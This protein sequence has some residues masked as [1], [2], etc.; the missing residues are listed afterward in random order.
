MQRKGKE[1]E[2]GK[3]YYF[4][5]PSDR[6]DDD[7]DTGQTVWRGFKEKTTVHGIPHTNS[8]AGEWRVTAWVPQTTLSSE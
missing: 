4:L 3:L 1:R 7:G 5:K 2:R 6:A 8:A